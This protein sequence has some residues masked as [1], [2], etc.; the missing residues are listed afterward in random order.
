MPRRN[1]APL[2]QD[3][4]PQNGPVT[5]PLW[6]ASVILQSNQLDQ[7]ITRLLRGAYARTH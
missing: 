1:A 3:G 5:N 7:G 6:F 4:D 2:Y